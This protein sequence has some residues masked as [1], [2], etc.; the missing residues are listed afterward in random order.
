MSV[1][2]RIDDAEVLW[3]AG[4]LEG[5]VIQVLIAVAATVRKR[6]P[7]PIPDSA[8]YKKFILDEIGK[9]TNGPTKNVDFYF[10]GRHHVPLQD[11]VY[12]FIRCGLVHEGSLPPTIKL[13]QPVIRVDGKPFGRSPSGTP[14]HGK[15][16]NHLALYDVTGFPIGWIWNLIRVVAEAPEN[17]DGFPGC[18][19]P[20]PPGYSVDAG[21][22]IEF[23][24][25]HPE[26]FPPNAPPPQSDHPR[27]K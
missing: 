10:D 24:D 2:A 4:R 8:A 26:R 13:T 7:K 18:A 1:R 19:Y 12:A 16:F 23:P 17:A 9:I 3:K 15:L 27:G 22:E 21:F 14:Y 5:A 20:I 6:Y 11:I 25:D